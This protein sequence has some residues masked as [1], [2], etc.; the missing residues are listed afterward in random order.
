[1]KNNLKN[2]TLSSA[3][4]LT[5]VACG[6]GGG[7]G[8]SGIGGSGF[9]SSGS[10]TGFGSIF[11]N[12]VEF[13]TDTAEFEIEGISGS[14]NDLTE[15]M[16]VKVSG[17][18]NADG[19]SGIATKVQFED[20]LKGPISSVCNVVVED[21]NG[22]DT[23]T[24]T[25]LGV[26]VIFNS[27]D[28]V[29]VGTDFNSLANGDHIQVSGFFD[30]SGALKAT[31]V[32]KKGAFVAGA[33]IVE[34]K[35]TVSA[36]SGSNFTL[37][38]GAASL[39]VDAGGADISQLAGGLANGQFVEVK[40]TITAVNSTSISA[41]LIKP[42]DNNPAEGA[43]V[44]IEGIITRFASSSDFDVDGIAVNA[45][46]AVQT[47]A[48]LALKAGIKVEVEGTV[49]NGVLQAATLKLR[50]GSVKIHAV[51][52]NVT[53]SSFDMTIAGNTVKV[54]VNTST[55]LEDKVTGNGLTLATLGNVDGQF[56][57]VRGIDDGSGN[58]IIATRVRIESANDVI[59][60]GKLDSQVVGAS[61]TVLGI[62]VNIDPATKFKDI[63]N[64][65]F[66]DHADFATKAKKGSLVKIKD[67]AS[68]AGADGIADEVELQAL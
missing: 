50:E 57:R 18:V 17:T 67:K 12:G 20:Q 34:A 11:V 13:E 56:L 59:L 40:G 65:N 10:V 24:C 51:A 30:D 47:P 49:S 5:L 19:V 2:Y 7:G 45:A 1:M 38:V 31:A 44:E 39:T 63:D 55:R 23:K 14:Q 32:V 52:S 28:T 46:G 60:Q 58:G 48:N 27:A 15:G 6:G 66:A 64:N 33:T 62:T 26:S 43:E 25:V 36:L 37:T 21:A 9:I 8:I 16:R 3:I 29:F 54:T 68:G 41:T 53:A 22:D 35:G 4:A 61:L 42:E